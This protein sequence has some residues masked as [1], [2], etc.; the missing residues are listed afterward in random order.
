MTRTS[1]VLLV[2]LVAV[3]FLAGF[4]LGRSQVQT[5]Y[6]PQPYP[7]TVEKPVPVHDTVHDTRTVYLPTVTIVHDTVNH[8]VTTTVHHTD[9]V[10]VQVPISTKDYE[11]TI[12]DAIVRAT[13]SGYEPTLER[14]TVENLRICPVSAPTRRFSIGVGVGYGIGVKDAS[15][16]VFSGQPFVGVSL[17]YN[18]VAF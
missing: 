15:N 4:L 5:A 7:V 18:L 12:N 14:L 2:G 1:I 9:T 11:E 3:S 6:C 10:Q 13:V 17:N 16:G 8:T